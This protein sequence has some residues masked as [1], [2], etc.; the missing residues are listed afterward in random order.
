MKRNTTYLIIINNIIKNIF[1]N[2]IN[3]HQPKCS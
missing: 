1:Y 2:R 3:G